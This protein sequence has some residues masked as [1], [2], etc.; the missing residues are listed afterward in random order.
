MWI[1]SGLHAAI[2]FPQY[3]YYAYVPNR[4][5]GMRA[6]FES[7]PAKDSDICEWMSEDFFPIIRPEEEWIK[8]AAA[9]ETIKTVHRLAQ[10]SEDTLDELGHHFDEI[11]TDAYAKFLVKIGEIG[12]VVEKRNKDNKKAGKAVY[13]YLLLLH[14]SIFK[15]TSASFLFV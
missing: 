11:G 14:R 7:M 4:P 3:D 15:G 5:L 6:S 9:L 1:T 8:E 12:E 2:N 10:P 13:S